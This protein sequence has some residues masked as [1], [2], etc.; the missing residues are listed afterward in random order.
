MQRVP[1]SCTAPNTPGL[2]AHPM[3]AQSQTHERPQQGAHTEVAHSDADETEY[4]LVEAEVVDTPRGDK[5]MRRP[6]RGRGE[7]PNACTA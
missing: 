6:S 4:M 5:G 2:Y 1:A 3:Q 7:R